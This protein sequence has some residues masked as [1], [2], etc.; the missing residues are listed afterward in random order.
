MESY[1]YKY[2]TAIKLIAFFCLLFWTLLFATPASAATREANA[3][4]RAAP[5]QLA[6][7]GGYYR[8][9]H[10]RYNNWHRYHHWH[11]RHHH[12]RRW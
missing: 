10:S 9:H 7:Y 2:K 11:H 4:A 5:I 3:P 12:W 6:Y 8:Y 1:L